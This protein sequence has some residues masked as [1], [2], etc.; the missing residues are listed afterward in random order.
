MNGKM[1]ILILSRTP[2]NNSNSFGN[3]FSNLF[4]GMQDVELYNICCQGGSTQN[5]IVVRTLQ[6]SESSVIKSL[7]GGSIEV[8][9]SNTSVESNGQKIN[10]V[11]KKHKSIGLLLMRDLIWKFGSCKYKKAIAKYIGEVQPDVIYLPIYAS[12]Y[13]CDIARYVVD[14][15]KVPVIGH[16]SDD[17]YSY[18]P[19]CSMLSFTYQYRHWLRKKEYKLIQKVLYIE[20]FAQNMKEEY[21]NIFKK[22]CYVIGK[23]VN[24]ETV[25]LPRKQGGKNGLV[26]FVY[27]GGIGGER[28][29]VLID[30]GRALSKQ[31]I[32]KC[33]LDIYTATPL[34]SEMNSDIKSI[35]SIVY[36]GAVSGSEVRKIQEEGDYLVHVESFSVQSVFETKM[37]FSTKIIDYLSTGNVMFAIGPSSINSIQIL[38]NKEMA[39]VV[40]DIARLDVALTDL[41]IGTLGTDL[42]QKNAY[43]YLTTKRCKSVIQE[44]ILSRMKT[45]IK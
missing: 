35:P 33:V 15:A 21:E 34:T 19:N 45:I 9:S 38:Q 28:Y 14:Y 3:T 44:S 22:P 16:I 31:S 5:D 26:H 37:S 39:V 18:P 2:W 42:L 27:T 17:L 32:K 12:L 29:A 30:L 36:H 24:P 11:A 6:M 10:N 7:I 41:L 20:V 13:M 8:V 40:D 43:R 23:S 4:G 1:K 25:C